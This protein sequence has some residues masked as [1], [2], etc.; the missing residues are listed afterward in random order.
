ML[1]HQPTVDALI[2]SM[3]P[4]ADEVQSRK[5][6]LEF[7]ERDSQL[8]KELG[9][10]LAPLENAFADM[11]SQHLDAYP[12]MATSL[13]NPEQL[14][15]L[16]QKQ[17]EY[18][19]QVFTG[20]YGADYIKSRL[21]VGVTYQQIGLEPRWYL[22]AYSKYLSWVLPEVMRLVDND[23]ERFLAY[24]KAITKIAMF[25]SELSLSAYFHADHEM[26]RLLAQVF[27]SNLEAVIIADVKG[28]ILHVN[29]SV[30]KITGYASEA[31]IGTPMQDLLTELEPTLYQ[32]LWTTVIAGGQ[33]QGEIWLKNKQGDD[34]LAWMN[35]NA[36][37]EATGKVTQVIAEFSDITA[38][39]QTQEA[40]A[41][42][43]EELANSNRELEQF[44]YVASHDLQ[45][46]LR[47]VASYTQLLA[48]RYK[49]KLDQDA[50]EFI[51]YA[52]DGATRMQALI[53]DLLT[54]SRIGTHGK[55]MELCETSVALERAESNLRLAIE[56]SGAVVTRDPMPRLE[57]DVSQL[58]QLF[59]NLIGNGIKFRG[60][61]SPV[62]HVGAEKKDGEWLFS[63]RDNGIGIAP[64]FF[65]RIFIIFQRLHGKHEY[66]GTGIGLSVCKK[67]VERHGGKIWI[68]SEVGKGAVF[69]FTLP[70][71]YG[72]R[73]HHG[74]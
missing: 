50:N 52:V 66:P 37:K 42:R 51:G 13:S 28:H 65:E 69:Y 1:L 26:L 46:P 30:A 71:H 60:D 34:Y 38:F 17:R 47:M 33:W 49:D 63:V 20:D 72:E 24:S 16:K 40:L 29:K 19:K 23:A 62:I 68:E 41:E 7:G 8:L 9:P 10:L 36:V 73:K 39:K 48:R 35:I 56:E 11:L 54:M 25:D 53:I 27:E 74:E 15:L 43:T 45:E 70:I 3:T 61:T 22:G 44:A 5:D 18:F 21:Q 12:E 57:A 64:D 32:D 58:T 55:R 4:S 6:V 14:S 31:L 67:I 2:D 59:Q